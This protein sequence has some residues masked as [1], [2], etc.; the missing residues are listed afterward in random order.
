MQ[1]LWEVPTPNFIDTPVR[2]FASNMPKNDVHEALEKT[3]FILEQFNNELIEQKDRSDCKTDNLENSLRI[4]VA[5]YED[6]KEFTLKELT[7]VQGCHVEAFKKDIEMLKKENENLKEIVHEKQKLIDVILNKAPVTTN[8]KTSFTGEWYRETRKSRTQPQK[9][10]PIQITNPFLPLQ[11]SDENNHSND[12]HEETDHNEN[13]FAHKNYQS[14]MNRRPQVVT[15][16]HQDND[17]QTWRQTTRKTV[18]GNSSYK[19]AV[20]YGRKTYIIGTSMVKGL[21]MREFNQQLH[22]SFAKLRP[23]PGA[24]IKQLE[25]Y[26]VPTL[27]DESPNRIIIHAGCNDV[28]DRNAT[29]EEIAKKIEE[30]AMMCRS[31]GVNE[32]FISSLICR[33]N[34]IL[35]DKIRRINFLTKLF[36]EEHGFVYIDNNNITE[37]DLWKDGIHLVQSGKDK[38]SNNFL[39]FLNFFY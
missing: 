7:K 2:S 30:F 29:P 19:D 13:K 33:K 36:C 3:T 9:T 16:L 24:S 32:I 39:H 15:N 25:Y 8:G 4:L 11:V 14:I 31:Y 10:Y 5:D 35:N 26:A 21:R 38:L 1:S 17:K 22:N 28:G 6:F 27:N 12:E 37:E 18:P 20:K 23:F 34:K